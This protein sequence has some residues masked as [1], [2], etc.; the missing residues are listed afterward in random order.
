[1]LAFLEIKE[2][3]AN[4][5]AYMEY[6]GSWYGYEYC[7]IMN[8]HEDSVTYSFVRDEGQAVFHLPLDV[9]LSIMW[10]KDYIK[11]IQQYIY[12]NEVPLE[13]NY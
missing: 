6:E 7:I 3:V 5:H 2:D 9:F 4:G 12:Y 11:L 13:I 8:V 1:M 10:Y